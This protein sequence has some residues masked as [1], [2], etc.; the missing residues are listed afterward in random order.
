VFSRFIM[1]IGKVHGK[2]LDM[3]KSELLND[4]RIKLAKVKI[5]QENSYSS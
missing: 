2:I 4:L 3:R 1:A 5:C